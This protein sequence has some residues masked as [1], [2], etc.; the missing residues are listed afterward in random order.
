MA[1]W[2]KLAAVC[3]LLLAAGCK[4]S[5]GRYQTAF[6]DL[7]ARSDRVVL[8][9]HSHLY[10]HLYSNV[11]YWSK[12]GEELNAVP[13]IVYRTLDLNQQQKEQLISTIDATDPK[14]LEGALACTFEAHHRL[15]FYVAGERVN[16]VEVCF[17]CGEIQWASEIG[18]KEPAAMVDSLAQFV[19]SVGFPAKRDWVMMV[20]AVASK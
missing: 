8:V 2:K 9:E 10:D 17:Q 6:A 14:G 18:G 12:H 19:N 15:E 5:P 1:F 20:K 13:E 4:P 3:L 11:E 7:I 16:Q